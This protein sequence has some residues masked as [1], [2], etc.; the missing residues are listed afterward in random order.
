MYLMQYLLDMDILI[1][2]HR[3]KGLKGEWHYV[4]YEVE[5]TV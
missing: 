3:I 4:K 2:I 1:D 5:N